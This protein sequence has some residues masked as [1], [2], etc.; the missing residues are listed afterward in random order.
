MSHATANPAQT[1]RPDAQRIARALRSGRPALLFGLR[2]WV[3]AMLAFY[4]SY[5]LELDNAFWAGT[6]AALARLW[7]SIGT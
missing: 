5:W 4:I 6:T 7:L 1:S 3:A 2:L